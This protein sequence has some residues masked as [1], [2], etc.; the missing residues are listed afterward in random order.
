MVKTGMVKLFY[1]TKAL[2]YLVLVLV[3]SLFSVVLSAMPYGL[4]AQATSVINQQ[5]STTIQVIRPVTK[6]KQHSPLRH[7][8]V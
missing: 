6:K 4:S 5:S 8:R 3:S 1:S 2:D 7:P